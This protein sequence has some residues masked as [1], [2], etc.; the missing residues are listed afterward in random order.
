M[1]NRMLYRFLV[2]TILLL[3]IVM[4]GLPQNALAACSIL[5]SSGLAA[6]KT[7]DALG[8]LLF[9]DVACPKDVFL[10]RQLLKKSGLKLETTM[11]ANRGFHNPTQ[12]SFSIFEIVSGQL[13]SGNNT[14]II[15]TG[16]FFFGHFTTVNSRG[17]LAADQNPEK[18]SL[19][20]EAFAW[21]PKKEVFNFY[22][23]R[24]DGKQG[25]WFYR[26]DSVDIFTDNEFLHRQSDPKHPQFGNQLRC[27]ACHDA[28]GPIMKELNQPHNDWWEPERKLDFGGRLLDASLRGILETLVPSDRLAKSVLLGI[29]K[30]NRSNALFREKKSISLQEQLRPLFCPMELNFMSD[31][32][33][34]DEKKSRIIIPTDF[35][36]DSRFL[37]SNS[38]KRIIISRNDYE[39]ALDAV[40]SVF[41]ETNLKD[42]DHAWLT[43]VKAISDKLAVNNLIKRG[44]IDKKFMMD[45]LDIDRTNPVFS[46]ARCGLLRFIPNTTISS[47]WRDIFIKNLSQSQD[48]AAKQLVE[49]LT[50][51]HQDVEFYKRKAE[52]FLNQCSAKLN[53]RYS[54]EKMYRLLAQRR[55]EIRSSEISLNPRGKILEPGFRVIFPESAVSP[56]PGLLKLTSTCD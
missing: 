32:T 50:N 36:V 12:G 55:A 56:I 21:D 22:E 1:E 8:V 52:I 38:K 20:I 39:L 6:I 14:F 28:G 53:N 5:T 37:Y 40:G 48:L 25:Q 2:I 46:T 54:V 27:S 15:K 30:L 35:F 26:G 45:V 7:A 34:N 51:P 44:V 49:S 16:D 19:M 11:V 47:N 43:P 13:T 17:Y 33:P 31:I 3:S 24:G 9:S 42:A 18:S 4:M 23:L 29:K 10:F 41:P